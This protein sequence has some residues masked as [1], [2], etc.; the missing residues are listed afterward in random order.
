MRGCVEHGHDA[1]K[2]VSLTPDGKVT[3]CAI[4]GH[5][6]YEGEPEEFQLRQQEET[7][8]ASPTQAAKRTAKQK[9]KPQLTAKSVIKEARA[10]LRLR[11][12]RIKQLE[13]ELKAERKAATELQRVV[14]AADGRR[15]AVV[16]NI[17]NSG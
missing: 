8:K 4:C 16:K 6:W 10:E 11:N 1:P 17:Q 14:D 5:P 2:R 7:E 9:S 12:Q 13:R 3:T 15:L